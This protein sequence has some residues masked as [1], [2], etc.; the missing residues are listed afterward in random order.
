MSSV[1]TY[2][3][4]KNITIFGG[5]EISGYAEDTMIEIEPLGDGM[6]SFVGCDG[7][8]ARS[9]DPNQNYKVT[10]K[11]MSTSASND[12]L[13]TQFELDRDTGQGMLPLIFKDLSGNTTFF[14]E[15]AWV[16]KPPKV[17]REKT[18][19]STEWVLE[20]GQA[21]LFVGGNE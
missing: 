21:E 8:T 11:L 20:T 9:I 13:S 3:P 1:T 2:D 4:K 17:T 5:L 6:K 16:T 15:Q 10:I 12:L 19:K 18:V 7:E 14:A